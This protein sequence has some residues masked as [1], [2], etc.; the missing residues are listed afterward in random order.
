MLV[1]SITRGDVVLRLQGSEHAVQK[2]DRFVFRLH[3]I[4]SYQNLL[5]DWDTQILSSGNQSLR[6]SIRFTLVFIDFTFILV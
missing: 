2:L 1:W 5:E 4:K 3:Q 6:C